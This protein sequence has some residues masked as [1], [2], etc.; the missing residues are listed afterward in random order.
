MS[1]SI[2]NRRSPIAG[3]VEMRDILAAH[4][5]FGPLNYQMVKKAMGYNWPPQWD[6]LGPG[7]GIFS[8]D[9]TEQ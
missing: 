3:H 8:P 9:E 6:N 2:S 4:V 7:E 5:Q 1:R